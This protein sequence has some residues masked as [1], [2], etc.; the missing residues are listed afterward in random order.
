MEKRTGTARI[1]LLTRYYH[2][3][4]SGAAIQA[5]QILTRLV[6]RGFQVTVLTAA[7]HLAGD[8]AGQTVVADGLVI[9][10]LPVVRRRS[11]HRLAGIK[12]LQQKSQR[13]NVLASSLTL[14]L[15][16]A[17][18]LWR[19]GARDEIAQLF[20]TNEF[21]F[22]V[23]TVARARGMHPLVQMT[24]LGSDDPA[25]IAARAK[26]VVRW[27]TLLAFRTAEVI[28]GYSSAQMDSCRKAG[29]QAK[30][31]VRIPG[32]V[33]PSLFLPV[34]E[35]TRSGLCE[36]LGLN[37]Q[38]RYIAFV[39]S[40]LYRKGIDV[41]LRAF[42][43]VAAQVEE[44]DLLIV[45]PCNFGDGTRFPPAQQELV[46][47]LRQEIAQ[48]GCASRIHW[49]GWVENVHHYLQVSDIFCFPTRQ[50]GFGIVIAEAMAV[51]L[52]VVAAR[53]EGV[54]TDIIPTG[55]EGIL[56]SG[57]HPQDYADA[58]LLLLKDSALATRLGNAARARVE[59]DLNLESSTARFERLYREL[60]GIG[61]A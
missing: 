59:S 15:K 17:W 61:A 16:A 34:D 53:L 22:L 31:I 42:F 10:Y 27:M 49:A 24:L 56:I 6:Q 28:I 54:T 51:G 46:T 44:V 8:L 26:G 19:E 3:N 21:S 30:Q 58:L 1:W 5:H 55:E 57:H 2:P 52:P 25:S 45:G 35:P 14:N 32:S 38:R 60:A 29:L 47:Q 33:E 50:E 9:R 36:T 18:I 11:W 13:L 48:A 39:G 20:G 40:A 41:L 43:R 37:G 4:F 23:T 12:A 7:D